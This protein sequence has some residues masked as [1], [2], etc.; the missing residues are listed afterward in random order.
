MCKLR[1]FWE[2]YA[3]FNP[4]FPAKKIWQEKM[5]KLD[6]YNSQQKKKGDWIAGA[7]NVAAVL[8]FAAEV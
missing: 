7:E 2:N 1:E 5:P 3:E 8:P 4:I 6:V